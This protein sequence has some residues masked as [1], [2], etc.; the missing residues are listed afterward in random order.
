MRE[1][2]ALA[3]DPLEA[4]IAARLAALRAER[5]WS[6]DELAERSGVSRA[7]LSR[8]ERGETSPTAAVLGRLS[9]AFGWT[10]SRLLAAAE[11]GE[12]PPL[13]R[14]AD[15]PVW[16]DPETGFRRR[17]VS[18]PASGLVAELVEGELPAGACVAYPGPAV[19]GMEQHLWLLAGSLDFVHAEEAWRLAPGDCLRLRLFGPTRLAAGRAGARYLLAVVAP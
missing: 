18:P 12:A 17:S 6:L 9:A 8:L 4:R 11:A 15:Q 19:R 7:T 3:A 13:L 1:I 2:A 14:R 10:L 5:A 16:T